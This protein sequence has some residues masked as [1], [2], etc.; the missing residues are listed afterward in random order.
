MQPTV[1]DKNLLF[2]NMQL[3]MHMHHC[4]EPKFHAPSP[5]LKNEQIALAFGEQNTNFFELIVSYS[6]VGTHNGITS[7]A[8]KQHE[9]Q[10][11]S[12]APFRVVRP[13]ATALSGTIFLLGVVRTSHLAA[14][15]QS[16][17]PEENM[18]RRSSLIPT[19]C[20]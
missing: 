16:A 12:A 18:T 1:L 9:D 8:V 5:L 19:R 15:N 6:R 4:A 17:A 10:K 20:R 14:R 2:A 11:M 7:R 13:V 3:L